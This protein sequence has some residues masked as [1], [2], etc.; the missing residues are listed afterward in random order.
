[1]EKEYKSYE[2]TIKQQCYITGEEFEEVSLTKLA[3]AI[4]S[5]EDDFEG[6]IENSGI[7][8]RESVRENGEY[9]PTTLIDCII[10][11]DGSEMDIDLDKFYPDNFEPE[12]GDENIGNIGTFTEFR[13]VIDKGIMS[14]YEMD[15]EKKF[16]SNY[17]KPVFNDR[18]LCGII[19]H[20]E[21]DNKADSDSEFYIESEIEESRPSSGGGIYLFYNSNQGLKQLWD[22]DELKKEMNV[23]NIKISELSEVVEFLKSKYKQKLEEYE[24]VS[25]EDDNDSP[26]CDKCDGE[27]NVGPFL[28]KECDKCNGSGMSDPV[29]H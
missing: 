28:D 1:M 20:Y 15:L 11:P 3:E 17:L 14:N 12:D 8:W 29:Y 13:F 24:E 10:N 23:E 4:V 16:D 7:N 27:G 9:G 25:E 21:Y 22:F 19:Q 26:W 6:F 5:G 18:S 2:L